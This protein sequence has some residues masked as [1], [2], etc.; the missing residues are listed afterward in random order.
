MDFQSDQMIYQRIALIDFF[1]QC[2][3]SKYC[4]HP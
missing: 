4:G 1:A 3:K 2:Q